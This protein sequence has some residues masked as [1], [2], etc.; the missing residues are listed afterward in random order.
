MKRYRYRAYPDGDEKRALSKVFGCV[1]VVF[2]DVIAVRQASY[3]AGEPYP[4]AGELSKRLLTAAKRTPERAWLSEVSSVP[5]Q[6]ALR[7]ADRAYRSFFDSMTGRRRGKR[8]GIPR[9]RT[10]R[11]KQSARFTRNAGFRVEETTHGVGFLTLPKIGRIRFVLSRPVPSEPSSVT[12]IQEADGCYYVSFVVA[13]PDAERLEPVQRAAGVDVGLTHLAAITYSDGTRQKVPNPRWLRT[14]ERDLARAQRSL[15]RKQ[16]GSKNR[17]KAR[18]RV[19][20]LHRKVRETRLDHHRKLALRLIRENQAIALEGLNVAGL[21]RTRMGKSVND[22]GWATLTRLI[23]EK[24]ADHGRGVRTISQCEPTSQLCSV[25]GAKDGPKPLHIRVWTCV[26]CRTALDRDF[27]AAVNIMVAA[28]LAET[29]NAC[30]GDV[31]RTL[32]C[33]DPGEAGTRRTDREI[34]AA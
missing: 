31:R 25:C 14:K 24:A 13:A 33:A 8:A 28:G 12:V 15:S 5:L 32:A 21:A 6:Q 11:G 20:V 4:T 1:R 23:R 2:N 3:L 16:R 30:G 17:E 22:A 29:L 19:S 34:A 26:E 7:D 27:N 18:R 9:F 10:R